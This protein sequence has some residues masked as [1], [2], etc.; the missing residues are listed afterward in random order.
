MSCKHC[1]TDEK[2]ITLQDIQDLLD[3]AEVLRGAW[4]RGLGWKFACKPPMGTL[5]WQKTVKGVPHSY[6]L[7]DAVEFQ[8]R[9]SG[10][11]QCGSDEVYYENPRTGCGGYA[12]TDCGYEF[13]KGEAPE[14][15]STEGDTA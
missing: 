9:R 6:G 12:C 7:E 2:N 13:P 11:R 8:A 5:V 4:L 1:Q 3:E 15:V 14:G 10:C